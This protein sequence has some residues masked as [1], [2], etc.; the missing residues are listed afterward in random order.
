MGTCWISCDHIESGPLLSISSSCDLWSACCI[1]D[2]ATR[3]L[4]ALNCATKITDLHRQEWTSKAPC[5]ERIAIAIAIAIDRNRVRR[6][7]HGT[8]AL[9]STRPARHP[10]NSSQFRSSC[11]PVSFFF[12]AEGQ[13]EPARTPALTVG[14]SASR[15]IRRLPPPRQAE[16]SRAVDPPR[17]GESEHG[18]GARQLFLRQGRLLQVRPPGCSLGW[19]ANWIESRTLGLQDSFPRSLFLIGSFFTPLV[20]FFSSDGF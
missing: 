12:L 1:H 11:L 19:L 4:D 10:R 7:N 17:R 2:E 13:A 3:V 18:E 9:V 14:G 15:R 20:F 5:G 8:A 16:Q 6:K